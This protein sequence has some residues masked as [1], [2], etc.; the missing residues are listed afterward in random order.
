MIDR[1][2]AAAAVGKLTH[3]QATA[4]EKR[5]EQSS[6]LPFDPGPI[7]CGPV[8]MSVHG[9]GPPPFEVPAFGPPAMLTGAARFLH[10]SEQMLR[11]ELNGKSLADVAKAHGKSVAGLEHALIS[12]A[13][14]QLERAA[15]SG[16]FPRRLQ[17]RILSVLSAQVHRMVGGTWR[18]AGTHG[19]V[20]IS[21]R[22][23]GGPPPFR[24][25]T[26]PV[27]GGPCMGPP[28][29]MMAPGMMGPRPQMNWF[30]RPR[31]ERVP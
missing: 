10:V 9:F 27:P 31:T 16:Y 23:A 7:A 8:G 19:G 25:V 18:F 4:I 15:K 30:A 17:K 14:A 5:I 12:A 3:A 13:Q 21:V 20:S 6:G 22:A 11:K 1:V 26:A 29:G 2:K 28:P 24:A